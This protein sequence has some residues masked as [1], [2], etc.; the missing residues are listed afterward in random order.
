MYT[1]QQ[2]ASSMAVL[3][4][5]HYLNII[6]KNEGDLP[7]LKVD[8]IFGANTK[9]AVQ[10]FQYQNK[11]EYDGIIGTLT[12]DKIVANVKK[13]TITPTPNAGSLQGPIMVGMQ[14][15]EVEKMQGYLNQTIVGV[16]LTTDG[17]FGSKTEEAV[18]KFQSRNGLT[19]DGKIGTKTFDAIINAI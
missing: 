3:K 17:A 11:L 8:G 16:P 2:G 9:L 15:L 18:V 10:F 1:I 14:G 19:A 7:Q 12:W 13:Y 5:Q 4:M 6:N